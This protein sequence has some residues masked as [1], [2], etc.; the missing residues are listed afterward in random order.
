[1]LRGTHKGNDRLSDT[2]RRLMAG[3]VEVRVAARNDAR[4]DAQS[5]AVS[6][7][8]SLRLEGVADARCLRPSARSVRR[9]RN[10]PVP[11][12]DR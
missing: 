12:H 9:T 4:S 7:A 8:R 6:D 11:T 10:H 1:V 5:R 2:I 3:Q